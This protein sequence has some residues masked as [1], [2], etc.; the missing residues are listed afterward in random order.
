MEQI[1]SKI[2]SKNVK[3][4]AS[5]ALSPSISEAATHSRGN[6]ARQRCK[7]KTPH[8]VR[9][10]RRRKTQRQLSTAGN[11]LKSA[12]TNCFQLEQTPK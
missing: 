2:L 4:P 6:E 11:I 10:M 3:N 12:R 5:L 8:P 9:L 7:N 1:S